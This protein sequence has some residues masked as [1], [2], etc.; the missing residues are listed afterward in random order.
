MKDVDL[1]G[2]ILAIRESKFDKS[3]FVPLEESARIAL[4]AYAEF[5]DAVQPGRDTS[6]FLVTE[7]GVRLH[8]SRAARRTFATLCQAVGLRPRLHPHRVGWGP[9]L[10]DFRHTFATPETSSSGIAPAW[11][12]TGSCPVWPRTSVTCGMAETFIGTFR[13]SPSSCVSQL[14]A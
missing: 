14:N 4:A 11:T 1:A 7:R 6:A 10:Q 5:R 12:W 13:R 9:R 8:P 2:G 3:R